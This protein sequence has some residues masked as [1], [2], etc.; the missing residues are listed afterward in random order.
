MDIFDLFMK[1]GLKTSEEL[2]EKQW[3]PR[4]LAQLQI[5]ERAKVRFPRATPESYALE[6]VLNAIQPL[7]TEISRVYLGDK[8]ELYGLHFLDR[9]NN[10][11]YLVTSGK[12]KELIEAMR[13]GKTTG[14]ELAWREANRAK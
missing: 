2:S 13:K 4:D 3:E 9:A 1:D 8:Y 12:I 5:G 7:S 6:V 11:R 14:R 10:K